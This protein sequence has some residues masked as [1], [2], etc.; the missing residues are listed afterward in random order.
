MS[1]RTANA[2]DEGPPLE[3]PRKPGRPATG[4]TKTRI[5]FY[6]DTA[7]VDRARNAAYW[8]S[9][10]VVLNELAERGLE[11]SVAELEKKNGGP[12]KPRKSK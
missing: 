11:R 7:V 4:A 3:A 1:K 5:S 6:I 12:F 10:R 9:P 8:A 2:A